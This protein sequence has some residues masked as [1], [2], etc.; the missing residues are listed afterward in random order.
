M[1][2]S[3]ID[4]LVRRVES[5]ERQNR[6]LRRLGAFVVLVLAVLGVAGAGAGTD[7]VPMAIEAESFILRDGEGHRRAFLRVLSDE[8]KK[9]GGTA[10]LS[11]CDEA[12]RPALSL[13]A[14]PDGQTYISMGKG[15]GPHKDAGLM[16]TAGPGGTS[17]ITLEGSRPSDLMFFNMYK[18]DPHIVISGMSQSGERESIGL[19]T[20]FKSRISVHRGGEV[21]SKQSSKIRG[22]SV[23]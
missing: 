19:G 5:L 11:S 15:I 23:K 3:T 2:K 20:M 13:I 8:T 9:S 18:D 1:D 4:A 22:W 16:L 10:I 7:P 17:S 21:S 12:G 14:A 6:H